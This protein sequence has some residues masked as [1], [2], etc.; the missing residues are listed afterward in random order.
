[1]SQLGRLNLLTPERIRDATAENVKIGQ[2][3]SLNLP[4]DFPQPPIFGRKRA[5]HQIQ[6]IGPGAFDDNLA[7]NTQSSSQWDGFRH[8]ADPKSGCF[9]NGI[10]AQEILPED[11]DAEGSK[12][13]EE[14]VPSRKLGI[15]AWAK[16]GIVGRGVL[17]DVAAWAEK[18][19]RAFDPFTAHN[20]SAVDLQACA[21]AE[22][23]TFETGDILLIRTGWTHAY[24]ALSLPERAT[25]ATL[26]LDQHFYA[27]LEPSDAMKDFLH[28][29][30]FAAAASDNPSLETWPV[31]F[32][33]SLH[34]SMLPL[35]G[36]PI[37]ELWDLDALGAICEKE[38]RWTFLLVSVPL[39]AEGGVAAPPNAVAMF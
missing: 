14:A 25:R 33:T 20:I 1:M 7:F 8:F 6:S 3:I 18:Q 32:A 15:D 4:L 9:Y 28:D 31:D 37:G 26:P 5:E 22:N 39:A 11:T 12:D 23:I 13:G 36:M 16:K 38:G 27:G 17:L 2:T 21:D 35:W 19:G 24:R 34:A 29:N 30:Y 10:T